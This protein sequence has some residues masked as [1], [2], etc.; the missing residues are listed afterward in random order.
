MRARILWNLGAGAT[1]TQPNPTFL[2]EN[3]SPDIR[4]YNITLVAYHTNGCDD[5]VEFQLQN[6]S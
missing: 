3:L 1:S 5:V 4:T 6:S 2:Y